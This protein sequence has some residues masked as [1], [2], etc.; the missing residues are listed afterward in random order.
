MTYCPKC[1]KPTNNGMQYEFTQDFSSQLKLVI[2]I[3]EDC[4][5]EKCRYLEKGDL[6]V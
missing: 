3:C 5:T 2:V 1:R 4:G 6:N